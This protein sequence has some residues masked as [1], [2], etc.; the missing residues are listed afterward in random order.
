MIHLIAGR[1]ALEPVL[2]QERFHLR[3]RTGDLCLRRDTRK[4]HN[5]ERHNKA[6]FMQSHDWALSENDYNENLTGITRKKGERGHA[7]QGSTREDVS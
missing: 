2:P 7:P 5:H 3:T 1:G 4:E 6:D